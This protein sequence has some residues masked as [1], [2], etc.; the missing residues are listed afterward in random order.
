M[1]DSP[2]YNDPG[3]IWRN[4]SVETL[5]FNLERFTGRRTQQLLQST[6][7]DI[8]LS[9]FAACLFAAVI[10][11]RLSPVHRE[12]ARLSFAAAILWAAISLFWFR[13]HIWPGSGV[14]ADS[15]VHTG[16]EHYRMVLASRRDHL[17]NA[18]IW[19]GPA[20]LASLVLAVVLVEQS[21]QYQRLRATLPFLALLLIWF[22]LGFFVRRSKVAELQRELDELDSTSNPPGQ[23]T[24]SFT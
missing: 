7:T 21:V 17:K 14:R 22:V 20:I 12:I 11:W 2:R 3:A 24:G 8:L 19:L 6:R 18:W 13:R 4:Q 5:A 15:L 23:P 16:L 1:P 9:V 10:S